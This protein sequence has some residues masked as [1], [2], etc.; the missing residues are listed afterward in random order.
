MHLLAAQLHQ[1]RRDQLMQPAA[2]QPSYIPFPNMA[3]IS[4]LS[5]TLPASCSTSCHTDPPLLPRHGAPA[6][7][8]DDPPT[9]AP[10]AI[11]DRGMALCL[12]TLQVEQHVLFCQRQG[13]AN[14]VSLY[15]STG[16]EIEEVIHIC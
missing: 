4:P 13:H 14:L 9:P 2:A 16:L 11:H 3:L 7:A 8:V 12:S 10:H 5:L 6:I 15:L 1:L